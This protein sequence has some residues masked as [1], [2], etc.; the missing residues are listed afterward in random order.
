VFAD[1][2]CT[3]TPGLE[4]NSIL[5]I[6][7]HV[8]TGAWSSIVPRAVLEMIGTPAGITVL[9]LVEPRV[10]WATGLI[11]LAGAQ[12]SPMVA[13]LRAEARSLKNLSKKDE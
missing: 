5:S 2:D 8:C 6:L 12:P 13:A 4:T 9:D 10:T 11:T 1:L 7:A 3:V